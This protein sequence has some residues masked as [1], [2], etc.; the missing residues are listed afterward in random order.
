M[1]KSIGRNLKLGVLVFSGIILFIFGVYFIGDK[2]NMFGSTSKIYGL[3]HNVNGLKLGNNVRYAGLN[4]GTVKKIELK[5]DSLVYVQMVIENDAF[6]FI[7]KDA[8]V[9]IRSDGLVGNMILNIEP[10]KAIGQ[11]IVSGDTL[12]SKMTT[13]TDDLMSSLSV[14]SKNIEFISQDLLT[15]TT[16]INEGKGIVNTLLND[17]KLSQDL[18]KTITTLKSTSTRSTQIV[19]KVNQIIHSLDQ[20]NT[21][22][23]LV[24]DTALVNRLHYIVSS[25][26]KTSKEVGITVSN[27]NATVLNFKNGKGAINYLTND[28]KLVT[29]IDSSFLLIDSTLYHLNDASIKLNENLEALKSNFLF[30]G[31]FKNKEKEKRKAAEK[32]NALKKKK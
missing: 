23:G 5:N 22:I 32:L 17:E 18:R 27:L 16:S 12:K 15:I 31:Y 10:Y 11:P 24:K 14:T 21:L 13:S 2:Q 28:E 19:D 4:I 8:V 3:F 20:P 1:D 26:E 6:K 7:K 9:S 30:S 29:K 25:F